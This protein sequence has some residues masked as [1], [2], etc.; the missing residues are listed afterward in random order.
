VSIYKDAIDRIECAFAYHKA[1]FNDSKEMIDYIFLDVNI[2]FEK[3]TGLKREDI[4][5]KRFIKDVAQEKQASRKWL[6]IYQEVICERK[7][8]EF[9]EYSE[10]YRKHYLIKAYSPLEDHFVTVFI[11]K[12]FEKNLREIS[13]YFMANMGSNIDYDKITKFAY[14]VTGA[15]YVAFNLFD[16]NGKEFTTVA[17]HGLTDNIQNELR[18]FTIDPIGRKWAYDPVREEKIKDHD[19]TYFSTLTELSKTVFSASLIEQLEKTFELGQVAVAKITKEGKFL[20]DFTLV[21]KKEETILNIELFKLYLSQLGLFIEKT[22][23]EK[24]LAD[25]QKRFYTLAEYAPI[26]FI[27]CD[28]EGNILYANAKLLDLMDSPSIEATKTIN[29]LAYEELKANGFSQKL[30]ECMS[31]DRLITHEMFY[32]SMWKKERWFK[33]YFT[34]VKENEIVVGANIVLDDISIKKK[35]ENEL[36][37]T[38]FRDALTNA[39]NRYA[40]DTILAEHLHDARE[41][42]LIG[43]L[44]V[45]DLDD[46]K[47]INDEYGHAIGDSVLIHFSKTVESLL[48]DNDMFIRTGGDEFLIYLYDIKEEKNANMIIERIFNKISTIYTIEDTTKNITLNVSVACS[49]GASFFPRNGQTVEELMKNAD[50]VLYR[51]K[52]A[53]KSGYGFVE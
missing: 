22:R 17:L 7:E 4:I 19:I 46:F 33:I 3:L 20:G 25:S 38:A 51:S 2:A 39:Y 35:A 47:E 43:C 40:L 14:D 50:E 10:E 37:E 31:A 48:R 32:T 15:S 42:D 1:V 24:S 26:G 41:N 13:E 53:S 23:L 5:G 34:P 49:I 28:K 45:I 12:T 18:I 8:I 30:K 9:E 44:A 29:L 16:E 6:H 11:N 52:R 21:F 27:S 36:R